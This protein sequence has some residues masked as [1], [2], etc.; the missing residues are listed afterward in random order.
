MCTYFAEGLERLELIPNTMAG[1]AFINF[2]MI[3][4][5]ARLIGFC[6]NSDVRWGVEYWISLFKK[7]DFD[8]EKRPIKNKKK[9]IKMSQKPSW[10]LN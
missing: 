6:M 2:C 5:L 9:L 3:F 1:S 4:H 10:K 8:F 7:H